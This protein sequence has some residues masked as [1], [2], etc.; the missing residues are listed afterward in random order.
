MMICYTYYMNTDDKHNMNMQK[1]DNTN[2][3]YQRTI[4]NS[5]NLTVGILITA[6]MIFRMKK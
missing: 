1:N 5:L 6:V 2:F 3:F 4:L